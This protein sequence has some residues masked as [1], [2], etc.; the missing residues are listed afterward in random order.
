MSTGAYLGSVNAE[1]TDYGAYRVDTD[2]GDSPT[3]AFL[4]MDGEIGTPIASSDYP[5]EQ[6]IQEVHDCWMLNAQYSMDFA[7]QFSSGT[8]SAIF[9]GIVLT[10]NQVGAEINER[11]RFERIN[12][13]WSGFQDTSTMTE[14]RT[15]FVTLRYMRS[16]YDPTLGTIINP[17]Y[18]T[19]SG[20]MWPRFELEIVV[21]W[22]DGGSEFG[23]TIVNGA[24]PTGTLDFLGYN[25][26]LSGPIAENET[27]A[28]T[29]LTQWSWTP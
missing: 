2:N 21:I 9:T 3:Y 6:T 16:Q 13:E 5:F 18:W 26:S 4:P 28:I 19:G 1:G 27:A 24:G 29:V 14:T 10:V 25:A 15:I 22:E 11:S 12:Y 20:G 8:I 17:F 7:C 23:D